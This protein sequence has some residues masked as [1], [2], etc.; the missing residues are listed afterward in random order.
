MRENSLNEIEDGPWK[1]QLIFGLLGGSILV[2]VL[3]MWKISSYR[4]H[5]SFY[6]L[7]CKERT[8]KSCPCD[9]AC[10]GLMDLYRG[11][12]MGRLQPW[13]EWHFSC[14]SEHPRW[15]NQIGPKLETKCGLLHQ[16]VLNLIELD[17]YP[18]TGSV[19]YEWF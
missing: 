1:T 12:G 2:L 16:N 15:G 3:V 10:Q 14:M 6:P 7:I 18:S 19:T 11:V 5:V 4:L 13:L 9:L 8:G 17:S